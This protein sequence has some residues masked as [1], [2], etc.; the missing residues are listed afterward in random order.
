MRRIFQYLM[1]M[2]TVLIFTAGKLLDAKLLRAYFFSQQDPDRADMAFP[3]QW[4]FKSTTF[5]NA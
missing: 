3:P 4:A 1:E 5:Q 2:F